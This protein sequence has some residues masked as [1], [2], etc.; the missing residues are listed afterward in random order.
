LVEFLRRCVM[1]DV[2]VRFGGIVKNLCAV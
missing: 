2:W 1:C